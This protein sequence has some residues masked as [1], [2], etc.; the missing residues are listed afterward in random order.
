MK[1]KADEFN[2]YKL[3]YM[4]LIMLQKI[5]L[6]SKKAFSF[7]L[8]AMM[9]FMKYFGGFHFRLLRRWAPMNVW[10]SVIAVLWL[11]FFPLIIYVSNVDVMFV[12]FKGVFYELC[13]HC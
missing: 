2:S 11:F 13:E 8:S 9:L 10:V 5:S 12:G 6:P 4:R 7:V 1:V 3:P